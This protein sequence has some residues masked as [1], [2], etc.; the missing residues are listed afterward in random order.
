VTFLHK[1]GIREAL[2]RIPAGATVEINGSSSSQLDPDVLDILEDFR[3]AATAK[4]IAVDIRLPATTDTARPLTRFKEAL[5]SE[6]P[7]TFGGR[8]SE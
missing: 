5:S 6:L 8:K 2:S 7:V 1:A 3:L 4:G